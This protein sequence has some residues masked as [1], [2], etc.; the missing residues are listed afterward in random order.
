LV[1]DYLA[2]RRVGSRFKAL[3]PFHDDHNPSLELNPERQSFKCWSCGVGGDIFDF[4]K[5]IEHVDFPEALRMLADR[6]GIV[7]ERQPT[8]AAPRGP[9]KTDL[10]EL[11]AWAEGVYAVALRES[12]EALSY[13]EGRGLTR[14][15]V[16]RFRLGLAPE[17]RGWF[18]GQARR[19]GYGMELLE[20]VGLV[21]LA[22]GVAT[23]PAR[24][25]FRGRLIFPIHDNQKRTVGFGGRI[26]PGAERA[27]AEQGRHV[28]KYLNTPETPLFRKRTLLYGADFARAAA[29]Q[30]G[31]VAVVEGYTDVIAA[32]QVGLENVVGTLGTALGEDHL[33]GLE[34][35][36]ERV[37]LVFD[38]DEAGMTAADR[39]LE[40]FLASRL[41][42]RVLTL[43]A[44]LDPCD[45]LI[46]RGA[47]AFRELVDRAPEPLAYLLDRAAA[48]FDLA[49]AEGTQRAAE[50]VLGTINATPR[51]HRLGLEVKEGKV[52]DELSRRLHVSLD[53]LTRMRRQLQQSA[54]RRGAATAGTAAPATS[55]TPDDPAGGPSTALAAPIRPVD[56][57][58]TDLELMQVAL[59]EPAAV[60]WLA[61]RVS[62]SSLRDAPLRAILQGCYDIH[63]E[64][65]R[66]SYENLMTRLDDPVLRAL[67]AELVTPSALRMPDSSPIP[68]SE[69]V[70]PA[71]W[72]ERLERLL[73]VLD[74]R[75]RQARL[76]DLKRA[77]EASDPQAD[78]DA[79]RAIELEYR[80]LLT[81]GR[82]RNS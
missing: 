25:R 46:R 59:A 75:A 41:D 3:C 13:V 69:G 72:R 60:E 68:P 66:P 6:A 44:G 63:G 61:T 57:D 5:N 12:S 26:L 76:E 20:A 50:W 14:A 32:H 27:M 48:R 35:L 45:F 51:A 40:L 42:L 4:V 80:R 65:Q 43:P 9:S 82:P 49:S 7:L 71:P 29:R 15:S 19:H 17:V 77:L 18:L 81:S 79:R 1:G 53:S 36:A 38:G 24:E 31:W 33:R 8:A 11:N 37:V 23:G 70:R 39:S 54:S 62:P 10:F 52:L 22:D 78:P 55:E 56:L 74:R 64:G 34:R 30:A 21:G 28:A 16:E 58:R 73:A 47:G 67:A 2:L